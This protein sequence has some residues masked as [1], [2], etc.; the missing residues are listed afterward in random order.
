L[1]ALRVIANSCLA[2]PLKRCQDGQGPRVLQ[3]LIP[4]SLALLHPQYG[5]I[6]R[7]LYLKRI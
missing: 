5:F 3:V 2:M 7:R 4:V 1:T 6:L